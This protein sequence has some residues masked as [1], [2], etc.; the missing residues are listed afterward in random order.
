MTVLRSP[1]DLRELLIRS[2]EA[3]AHVQRLAA[4][5]AE[6]A[7]ALQE[8]EVHAVQSELDWSVCCI[9]ALENMHQSFDGLQAENTGRVKR[10]TLVSATPMQRR[11]E[12]EQASLQMLGYKWMDLDAARGCSGAGKEFLAERCV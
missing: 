12:E 1:E 5:N 8:A 10:L 2:L 9:K 7:K 4:E 11:L 6:L 3:S